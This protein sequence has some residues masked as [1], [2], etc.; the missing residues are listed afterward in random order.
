MART[1]DSE[2]RDVLKDKSCDSLTPF[3]TAANVLVD[4][5]AASDC[6]ADLSDDQLTQTE[7]WLAAHFTAVSDPKF[8][9]ESEQFENYRVKFSRGN[10]GSQ[11]GVLST[12]FGAM[13]NTL[14]CGCLQELDKR[15]PFLLA[16]GGGNY[17]DE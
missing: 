9:K 1:T 16:A 12:Q 14:S 10:S 3:I 15:R 11:I 7:T 13:A 4:K 5:L 6:G 17:T 8:A 2:V